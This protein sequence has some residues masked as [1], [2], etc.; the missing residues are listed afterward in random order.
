MKPKTLFLTPPPALQC[1]PLNCF[2]KIKPSSPWAKH[3]PTGFLPVTHGAPHLI[4]LAGLGLDKVFFLR[5]EAVDRDT[6][7]AVARMVSHKQPGATT[8]DVLSAIV[9]GR[10]IAIRVA[11][12]EG[13]IDVIQVCVTSHTASHSATPLHS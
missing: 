9:I 10:R 8:R 6:L 1:R 3:F 12:L 7:I 2:G 4:E 13:V 5:H 11:N